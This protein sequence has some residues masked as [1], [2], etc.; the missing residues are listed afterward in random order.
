MSNNQN[1][2][3]T[4]LISTAVRAAMCAGSEIMDVY[5]EPSFD[6]E[7]KSD[8]SP[9][10]KADIRANAV[11]TA[12]LRETDLPILSE[13]G[14]HLPYEERQLWKRFWLTDPLDGTSEFVA[15]TGDFC[16]NIALIENTEPIVGVI[17]S[18]VNDTVW[19]GAMGLGAYKIEEATKVID[20]F[21]FET[22][23]SVAIKLPYR[24]T[25][26]EFVFVASRSNLNTATKQFIDTVSSEY[27][28]TRIAHIG[29]ALKFTFLADGLADL[30]PRFAPTSEWDTAAG[31]ALLKSMGGDVFQEDT[32]I[33]LVYNKADLDNPG[34]VA[35]GRKKL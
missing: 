10:T 6:V 19:F 23:L 13:E 7:Y 16:V 35:F 8:N 5:C 11:I 29:S 15:K 1:I 34:F 33:P 27:T 32:N 21:S 9:L 26:D 3:D 24:N 14:V 20:D 25:G 22:F 17:Y 28:K 31:H 30:Y 2:I 18:P 4:Y 12:V